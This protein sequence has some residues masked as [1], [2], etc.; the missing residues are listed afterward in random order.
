MISSAEG[1]KQVGRE[2]D[3][4]QSTSTPGLIQQIDGSSNG[5]ATSHRY[6]YFFSFSREYQF[7]R[8]GLQAEVRGIVAEGL[9]ELRAEHHE[10]LG[11]FVGM[12]FHIR[13]HLGRH[14]E[15]STLL[16]M[17]GFE[18]EAKDYQ[19]KKLRSLCSV[20]KS[21]EDG[22]ASAQLGILTALD[23]NV[24]LPLSTCLFDEMVWSVTCCPGVFLDFVRYVPLPFDRTLLHDAWR[25][26]VEAKADRLRE[27]VADM[28][29]RDAIVAARDLQSVGLI[30]GARFVLYKE[31]VSALV[32][33][34]PS[35]AR[36][37]WEALTDSLEKIF[38]AELSSKGVHFALV[39]ALPSVKDGVVHLPSLEE[40][41]QAYNTK[42]LEYQSDKQY[43]MDAWP[44]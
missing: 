34:L 9:R 38:G 25:S 39:H 30:V 17:D 35:T 5:V 10:L 23:C 2:L 7:R 15:Q 33:G 37:S 26:F 13:E 36:S 8:D 19:G 16:S 29:V 41:V 28:A 4:L 18:N 22:S 12:V 42:V 43:Q 40:C 27:A 31:E 44:F 32:N 1:V 3:R 21:A 11:K 20:L 6:C 14:L 24:L